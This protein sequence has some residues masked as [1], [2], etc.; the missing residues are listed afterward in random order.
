[1]MVTPWAK[2]IAAMPGGPTPLPTTDAAPA[3]MNKNAKGPMNSARSLGAIRLVMARSKIRLTARRD[4]VRPETMRRLRGPA[5]RERG[6][7]ARDRDLF[8]SVR[9]QVALAHR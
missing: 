9:A 1:M 7:P 3:P 2:A 8:R 6:P 5:A 4:Q